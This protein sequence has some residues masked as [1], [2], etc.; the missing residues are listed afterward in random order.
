MS[1]ADISP[2]LVQFTSGKDYEDAFGRFF[3]GGHGASKPLQ[4]NSLGRVPRASLNWLSKV[5]ST[6]PCGTSLKT[7]HRNKARLCLPAGVKWQP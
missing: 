2:Y 1:R 7:V 5:P 4:C 6:E 3:G